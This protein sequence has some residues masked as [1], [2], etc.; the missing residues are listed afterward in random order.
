MVS[1][2]T[3]KDLYLFDSVERVKQSLEFAKNLP[4]TGFNEPT[5]FHFYW[6]VPKD[7]SRKQV[8]PIKSSIV[9]Q[10]RSHTKFILW[11][12]ID[13]SDNEFVKPLLPYIETRIWDLKEESKDTPLHNSNTLKGVVDDP[14]CYL[15]GDLFRLLCLHKYGGVYIDMD[16]VVLRDFEP[17]LQHEFMYQ[18]GSTGTGNPNEP[19]L[20]QNGAIMRLKQKSELSFD[21]LNELLKTPANP[22]TT[23][24]GSDLYHKVWQKNKNWITF[25]CAWFNTEWGMSRTIQ[26]FKKNFEGNESSELFDGAFTWHW[27]NKWDQ[28]IEDG[29]KFQILE[30]LIEEKFEKI[31]KR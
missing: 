19:F 9:T 7:F 27:H 4:N 29:C 2:D 16:V 12:N 14:L 8:L 20:K 3:H 10:N 26:P 18:W 22:D 17:I 23:C 31:N 28:P 25:P 24:W 5:T 1:I 21:L 13:L 6:R 30:S 15:G 11:S